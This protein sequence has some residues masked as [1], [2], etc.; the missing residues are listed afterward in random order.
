MQTTKPIDN[1]QNNFNKAVNLSK[2]YE[3]LDNNYSSNFR[4]NQQSGYLSSTIV[5]NNYITGEKVSYSFKKDTWKR[6]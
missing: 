6:I 2:N 4:A 3:G 1:Y 5:S